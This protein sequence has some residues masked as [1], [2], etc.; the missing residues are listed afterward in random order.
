MSTHMLETLVKQKYILVIDI[1]DY[2]YSSNSSES[3][4]SRQEQTCLQDFANV[5]ISNMHF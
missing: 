3:S 2:S 5:C 4:E 1:S